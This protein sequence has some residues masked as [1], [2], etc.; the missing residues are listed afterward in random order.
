MSAVNLAGEWPATMPD[1]EPM[2]P[3]A[4]DAE[5]APVSWDE[6]SATSANS[7][8]SYV[9]K[10]ILPVNSILADW[11]TYA[12]KHTEGA[13]CYLCGSI[14]PVVGALLERRVWMLLGG[15]RKYPNLFTLICGKP[16]DRKSTTIRMS[17]AVARRCLPG[18]AFIPAS[19]S[20][21][22]LFDEFD[23][24]SGGRPDKLWIADDA[25]SVLTDWQKTQNGERNATRFLELYDCSQL[26]ETFRRNKKESKDGEAKR[27]IPETSTSIVFGATFNVACF[28]GQTVRAGM[29]RRFL[30]YV[31][32]RRGCDIFDSPKHDPDGVVPLIEA[33]SRCLE[34][35]GE[36]TFAPDARSLWLKYQA[37]NRAEMDAANPLAEE[38]ISRLA[39]A[40][41][42][43]LAV[44]MVFEASMWAKR[45]GQWRCVLTLEALEC[46]MAHVAESL[47]AASWLDGIAHRATIAEDAEVLFERI[48]RD[49]AQ[50]QRGPT[51][52]A[53][54]SDLTRSYCH[55]SG[56]RG[57]LR[58][59]DLYNRL[60]PALIRQGKAKL[61]VK[62]GKRETYAFRANL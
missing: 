17:A 23:E 36:M 28:Q 49:F 6:I 54:R 16:G 57:A 22:S 37:E 18:N 5:F 4:E 60:I 3:G 8:G 43:T 14:L 34:I 35:E 42:Q 24:G 45:G 29:A 51:I 7:A 47:E 30:Y 25:N 55:D 56:R 53:T 20:P 59:H 11:F 31:A 52:Y 62:D 41:A 1:A 2:Q 13:D 15:G 39:S 38:L 32:E 21:E 12:R 26:S 40:P 19:F 33:F 9:Q 58:P 27:V 10:A 61:A 46:A 48:T 44:A 50:Q